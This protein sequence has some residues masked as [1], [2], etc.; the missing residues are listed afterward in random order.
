MKKKL[1]TILSLL[2][3][4]SAVYAATRN[5]V[6]R[7]DGEGGLGTSAKNWLSAYIDTLYTDVVTLTDNDASP[8]AVG[9]LLY[10]N[11]VA[12]WDDGAFCWYDDDEIK[13]LVDIATLPTNDDYVVAYDAAIDK[14]YMK[15]DA[16]SGGS[17][18]WDDITNPDASDEIDFGAH[19]IELNVADFQIGDG[20]GSNYVKFDGTPTVTFVGN[21]D[22]DYPDDSV[23]DA[24]INWGGL[25]DLAA[26]GVLSGDCVDES[27][28]AD[29]G[30]DSE[31]YNNGSIDL[32]HLATS[33]Y[34]KD[35]VTT[36]PIT[37][38]AE[39]IFVGADSDVTVA[40]TMLKDLVTTAPITGGT[41]D[42]FPGADA[43]I[44]IAIAADGIDSVHYNADSIDNEH[45]NWTD[46]D[47]LGDE[48]AVTLAAT[49]TVA[50][51]E[52]TDDDQ[53]I[54]FTTDNAT[55][56]S[57][58]D[59]H[60]SPD[61]GT[62]TAT[63]FA[64]GGAGVTSV[65]AITGDSATA[66]F[67]AGTIEHEYGG[68]EADISSY[69]GLVAITGGSTAEVDAKSELEGHIAD[70]ADFAEADGD[71]W[72][73]THDLSGATVTMPKRTANDD[74]FYLFNAWNPNALY[75]T[76]T[77]ICFEPNLPANITITEVTITLDANPTTEL[78]WDL[79]W[80]D[81]F[82]GLGNAALIV[83]IDTTSGTTDVDT[84][85]NDATV[86]AGKCL[87]IE[88]AADPDSNITQV[89]V[90]IRYDYD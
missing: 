34:A 66:F 10:D 19:T 65:D 13:Y 87:Y 75:D 69:T 81:A 72:T 4:A 22:I 77:Q 61:T 55:L 46:I 85:F 53:E 49:V 41:N 17:T 39:N 59:F 9:E 68:L 16:D 7:A 42:I 88:M 67:D 29:N 71:T 86:A 47:N 23:D 5:I 38:A 43:D 52:S 36:S 25:T 30:I 11:T 18:A 51:D 2:I 50:D 76:D 74:R 15:V 48:G 21:A 26:G 3:I 35:L 78:D 64:G 56:E 79:K 24:D 89:I 33:V 12:N 32:V 40:I 8:D 58:G 6:P 27:H 80:A 14:F 62:V 84:G 57:D 60:Y 44:T 82:I 90:K 83:A 28:I 37:G 1:L 73:G 63:E 45:I 20:A 70:V 54:V 31:H